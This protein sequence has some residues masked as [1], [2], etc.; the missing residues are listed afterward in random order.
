MRFG[1][2]LCTLAVAAVFGG[3]AEDAQVTVQPDGNVEV[4]VGSALLQINRGRQSG[5]VELSQHAP[6]VDGSHIVCH[7]VG[8]AEVKAQLTAMKERQQAVKD[9]LALCGK[10]RA[11]L[12]NDLVEAG[13]K[14]GVAEA[15]LATCAAERAKLQAD[16]EQCGKDRAAAEEGLAKCAA[17]RAKLEEELRQCAEV[18]RPKAEKALADCGKERA[19]LESE[20]AE[21]VEKLKNG[22]SSSR[23]RRRKNGGSISR[24]RRRR[25]KSSLM[26]ESAESESDEEYSQLLQSSSSPSPADL[27][28]PS[29]AEEQRADDISDAITKDSK[30]PSPPPAND[31][32]DEDTVSKATMFEA[33]LNASVQLA[34]DQ[35]DVLIA[36]ISTAN[37]TIQTA[38][39]T[40]GKAE[41]GKRFVSDLGKAV[42]SLNKFQTALVDAT[43]SMA[44]FGTNSPQTQSKQLMYLNVTLAT[45]FSKFAEFPAPFAEAFKD[46]A[47]DILTSL[48]A[49]LPEETNEKVSDGFV[50]I[51]AKATAAA[52][53][54]VNGAEAFVTSAI[55]AY[56]ELGIEEAPRNGWQYSGASARSG[57]A[58]LAAISMFMLAL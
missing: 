20:L 52:Q 18:D 6:G 17:E 44:G 5:K 54:V 10:K 29:P 8:C 45:G 42:D 47:T 41:L 51:Q 23:R 16:L 26:Q 13:K 43:D 14:R 57:F 46:M 12:T 4:A 21:L 48:P 49:V 38:L 33:N 56:Q 39:E 15:A 36:E 27:P 22:G 28:S 35:F 40:S 9:K 3:N 37:S 1:F 50:K 7:S 24:R 34:L 55:T 25:R 53:E 11:E 19:K 30:T 31:T 2:V 58:L 32:A